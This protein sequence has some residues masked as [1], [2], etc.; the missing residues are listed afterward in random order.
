MSE[1]PSLR[2]K[3]L[4][5]S[6]DEWQRCKRLIL[7]KARRYKLEIVE[8]SDRL[9]TG[10]SPEQ[11]ARIV[12]EVAEEGVVIEWKRR[13]GYGLEL[14]RVASDGP[15]RFGSHPNNHGERHPKGPDWANG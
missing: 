4:L 5:V 2:G 11:I 10:M 8:I 15:R 6:D 7:A 3:N 9:V 14:S 1:V 12:I 13:A